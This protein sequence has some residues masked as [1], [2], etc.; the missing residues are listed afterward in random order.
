MK[1]INK[2][3][4]IYIGVL[5][6]NTGKVFPDI[7]EY[8]LDFVEK[9]PSD[10]FDGQTIYLPAYEYNTRIECINPMYITDKELL[11]KHT[12]QLKKLHEEL[13]KQ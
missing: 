6:V 4:V 5:D 2:I 8:I 11:E 12:A 3:Y 7:E 13:N 9:M 1:K 10:I